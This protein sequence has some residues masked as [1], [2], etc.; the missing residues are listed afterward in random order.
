MSQRAPPKAFPHLPS[1]RGVVVE[2]GV[3]NT[4]HFVEVVFEDDDFLEV[5]LDVPAF[6]LVVV[7][8][9]PL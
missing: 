5:D 7:M 1:L 6:V 3:G 4:V 2:E 9:H 8:V